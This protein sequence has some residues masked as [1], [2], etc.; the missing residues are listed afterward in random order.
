MV[1][2]DDSALDALGFDN[3]ALH[4]VDIENLLGDVD[5]IQPEDVARC[6]AVYERFVETGDTVV[7]GWSFQP[8][9]E[10][11]QAWQGPEHVWRRGKDGADRRLV[12]ELRQR[13]H[14][15]KDS[16]RRGVFVASGDEEFV[17]IVRDLITDGVHVTVVS[18][19]DA[20]AQKLGNLASEIKALPW[21]SPEA[22]P[23]AREQPPRVG[24]KHD[25]ANLAAARALYTET[26]ARIAGRQPSADTAPWAPLHLWTLTA[27]LFTVAAAVNGIGPAAWVNAGLLAAGAALLAVMW[28]QTEAPDLELP[29]HNPR[30]KEGS[31]YRAFTAW[32][33]QDFAAQQRRSRS[34]RRTS[35]VF[36]VVVVASSVLSAASVLFE[37]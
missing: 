7:V 35:A 29:H 5:P 27:V 8:K 17:G 6:A 9:P 34:R 36:A 21:G 32:L 10:V 24:G 25:R 23:P 14:G 4:V 26:R 12:L 33:I 1:E 18:R 31:L 11:Q 3:R 13:R 30:A 16:F 19:E 20:L 28:A 22:R 2:F 15:V 37:L